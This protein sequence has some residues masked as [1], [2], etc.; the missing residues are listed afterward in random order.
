MADPKDSLPAPRDLLFAAAD[1]AKL[2]EESAR[3]P[4]NPASEVHGHTLSRRV[5]L[6]RV[7]VNLLRVPPGKE[8][9]VFHLHHGEE[10]WVYVLSGQGT[11]DVGDESFQVGPGD[12]L[13]FPPSTHGHHLRN[14]GSEDLVY[15]CGGEAREVEVADFPRLKRRLASWGRDGLQGRYAVYPMEAEIPFWKA[16]D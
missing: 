9:F 10:E 4:Y 15:L 16:E 13:G 8:S 12:F 7:G 5:G 11:A 2:P 6:K 1:R 3:H 14:P